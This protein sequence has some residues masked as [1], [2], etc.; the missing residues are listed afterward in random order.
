MSVILDNRKSITG[1]ILSGGKSLRMGKN[2]AFIKIEGVPII[3]RINDLFQKLFQETLIVTNRR[4]F[5]LHLKASVYEDLLPGSGALGGL[6]TGLFYSSFHYSFT[7]ACDMPYLNAG[8]IHYLRQ[9]MEGHDVV[10]PRTEDGLQPLHAIY[11]KNCIEPIQRVLQNKKT[12]IIDFYHLVRV[13]I[14]EPK[15]ILSI[16]PYMESFININTPE[17]LIRL[18]KRHTIV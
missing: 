7:V 4:D 14:I 1:A 17:E 15:E 18:K 2:K 13:K 10:V 12:R 16:D 6:Y 5:Y 11:S 3:Q 8:L 9:Y